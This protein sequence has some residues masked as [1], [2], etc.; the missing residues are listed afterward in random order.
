MC[1]KRYID[2]KLIESVGQIDAVVNL[3]AGFDTITA[4]RITSGELSK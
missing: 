1:R 3:G 2:E 4:R